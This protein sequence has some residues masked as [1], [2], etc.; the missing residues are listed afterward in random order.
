MMFFFAK[1]CRQDY[2]T[3]TFF[4]RKNRLRVDWLSVV[5]TKLRGCVEVVQDDNDELIMGDDV[6]QLSEWVDPYQ[7]ALSNDLEENSNFHIAENIF[8]DIDAKELNDV[9]N[10][11]GH[12]QVDEDDSDEINIEDYDG[13][14]DE[15]IDKEKG[16]FD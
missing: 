11:D 7:V 12:T 14:E 16:N 2:Y 8:V 13:D 5:K 15:L 1:Q 4:F 6:F 3:Y 10:S 9:L